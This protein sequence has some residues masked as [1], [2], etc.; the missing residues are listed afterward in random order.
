MEF[1]RDVAKSVLETPFNLY[2]DA[3]GFNDNGNNKNGN[4]RGDSTNPFLAPI[5]KPLGVIFKTMQEE[6]DHALKI[7]IY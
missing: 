5:T 6:L 2:A 7:E 4:G 1:V 3:W